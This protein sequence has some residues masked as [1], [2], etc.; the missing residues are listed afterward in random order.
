MLVYGSGGH[1]QVIIET[2]KSQDENISLVFDDNIESALIFGV[3]VVEY[4]NRN[5]KDEELIIGIGNNVV[6]EKIANQVFHRFG[7][8]I[9]EK[10][11]VSISAKVGLGSVVFVNAVVNTNARVGKHVVV[12]SGAVIDHDCVIG[13]FVHVAP[14]AT[15]CGHVEVGHGSLIGA[16]AV[17]I[18]SVK[19][20]DGV[21]VGA[22]RVVH[23]DVPSNTVVTSDWLK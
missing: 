12:N 5:C 8:V 1:A 10:A 2:L 16:G 11:Y 3:P 22:G 4:S 15:L 18:P 9:H 23:R 17:I 21:I 19:I 7:Q 6:R 13:D 20:G 14:N